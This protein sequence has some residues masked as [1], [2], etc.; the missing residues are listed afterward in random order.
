MIKIKIPS[1]DFMRTAKIWLDYAYAKHGLIDAGLIRSY[2]AAE[3]DFAEWLVMS[4][5]DGQLPESKSNPGY[6][7]LTQDMRIQVKSVSKMPSNP[8][9]YIVSEKDRKNDRNIGATHY[10]FVFF[11]KLIPDVIYLVDEEF[12]RIFPSKREI[13]R[14]DLKEG[15]CEAVINIGDF[16][17]P[18]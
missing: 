12:V 2:K 13:K 11:N 6:D 7:V 15:D 8:H 17:H 9:G 16:F 14:S 18:D 10:A 3:A 1:A 4:V 5:F